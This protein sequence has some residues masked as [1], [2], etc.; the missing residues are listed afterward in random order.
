[1][2]AVRAATPGVR[3]VEIDEPDGDG[4]LIRVTA[5]GIC[6][7]DR[8][9]IARGSTQILGHEISGVTED[10]TPVV[11]EALS[12]CGDCRWCGQGRVNLCRRAGTEILGMTVPGGM[13]EHFRVPRTSLV[14]IPDGL[15]TEDACLVE[16]GA[17][18][19]HA[20][21]K[22]GVGPGVRVAVVGGGA[23]GL[24]AV[25][26]AQEQGAAE[27]SLEARHPHQIEA[28]ER[29]GATRP[30]E[31]Y[32]LV[33]E[34]SGA[35]SGL[36]RAFDLARPL[37]TVTGVSVYPPGMTWPYRAAFLKEVR[38]MPSLGYGRHDGVSELA[39]VAAMLAARTEIP[40]LLI[41]HRFGIDEAE[42]AFEVAAERANGTFRVVVHPH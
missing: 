32:D 7:S 4:E 29:L 31:D 25:L 5:V 1:M 35:E 8:N 11:V 19:W 41:T 37:G 12:S 6:A 9:Y 23:V 20:V 10:G 38:M 16:P 18:A 28:G 17:V 30:S 40:D 33:V 39:R 22:G 21:C 27:V 36:A 14:P 24:L 13:A 26:A 2:K 42:R 15:R 3:V 34:A